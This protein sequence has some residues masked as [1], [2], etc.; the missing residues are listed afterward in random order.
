MMR[1]ST[2]EGE[3]CHT[4]LKVQWINSVFRHGPV[5]DLPNDEVNIKLAGEVYFCH[6]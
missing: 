6:C 5:V 4:H 2:L 3:R 1:S